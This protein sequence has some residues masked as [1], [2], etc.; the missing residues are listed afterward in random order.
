MSVRSPSL[1]DSRQTW[2]TTPQEALVAWLLAP[3]FVTTKTGEQQPL[4]AS[5]VVVYRAMGRKFIREVLVG[6]GGRQPKAWRDISSE[7]IRAFLVGNELNKGIRNRY[8]RL[9]ERLFDHLAALQL[10]EGNPARG[11][12][13]KEPSRSGQHNDKTMWLSEAQQ[14]AVLEKL[15]QGEGWKAQ[16]NRALIATV[17]GG[18]LKVSEVVTLRASAVGPRQ[19]DGSLYIN[20]HPEGAGRQHRTKVAPFG[21]GVLIE[22]LEARSAIA[23]PGELLFPARAVGGVLHPA[24]VYRHVAA[25]LA[26]AGIDPD[27]V[28]RRGARTLRNTFA[29]QALEAGSPPAL[30]G[31]YLGHRADRSTRYYVALVKNSPPQSSGR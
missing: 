20:V 22:W 17:L 26:E 30:V 6:E 24:T 4:R 15:P 9:L 10:V 25:V 16:R 8:V 7:D 27:L 12:A 13:M 3:D 21:A 1:F 23:L 29:I 31:E 18:G 5:S 19:E 11:L 28:K 14:T 2:L